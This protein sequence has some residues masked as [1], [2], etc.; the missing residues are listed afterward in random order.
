MQRVW[1]MLKNLKYVKLIHG[2][3]SVDDNICDLIRKIC[4]LLNIVLCSVYWQWQIRTMSN[5]EIYLYKD[6]IFWMCL[7]YINTYKVHI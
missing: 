7:L 6:I 4:S 5:D 1:K 2:I 3:G